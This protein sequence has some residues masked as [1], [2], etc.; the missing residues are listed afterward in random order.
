MY[1][2][3]YWFW[4]IP[5]SSLIRVDL[6]PLVE[7]ENW[8]NK[9]H[10]CRNLSISRSLFFFLVNPQYFV[11]RRYCVFC[12]E[13][14]IQNETF[15]HYSILMRIRTLTLIWMLH[16][17]RFFSRVIF[18]CFHNDLAA[19]LQYKLYSKLILIH[20]EYSVWCDS[21]CGFIVISFAFVIYILCDSM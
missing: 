15:A 14:H 21:G 5:F 7:Y 3:S 18:E 1:V 9:K 2:T 19:H 11:L 20:Q 4:R 10:I 6:F 16:L 17:G 12:N 8:C 13:K